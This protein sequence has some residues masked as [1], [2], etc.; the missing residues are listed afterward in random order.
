MSVRLQLWKI[1]FLWQNA[2]AVALLGETAIKIGPYKLKD[3]GA[4]QVKVNG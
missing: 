2:P 4:R 1:N 3:S